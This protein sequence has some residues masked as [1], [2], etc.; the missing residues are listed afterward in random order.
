MEAKVTVSLNRGSA[1]RP[2]KATT[3]KWDA[4]F[5]AIARQNG[6]KWDAGSRAWFFRS[7]A[8]LYSALVATYGADGFDW[9]PDEQG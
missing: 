5:V 9:C 1:S 3:P 2:L 7:P 6:G 4:K 8:R